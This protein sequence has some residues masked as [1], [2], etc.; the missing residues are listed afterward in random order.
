VVDRVVDAWLAEILDVEWESVMVSLDRKN[1]NLRVNK[2]GFDKFRS[3]NNVLG[4][5]LNVVV[6]LIV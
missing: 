2:S 5:L 6:A 1:C 3:L 4:N